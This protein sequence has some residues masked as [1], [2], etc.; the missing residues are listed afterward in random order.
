[1]DAI[2]QAISR[3]TGVKPDVLEG[4]V[5]LFGAYPFAAL[6]LLLP[7][8]TPPIYRHIYSIVV[9]SIL[10]SSTFS[11]ST[12]LHMVA[13]SA[14]TYLTVHILKTPY[15]PI[16]LFLFNMGYL[17]C[18]LIY[19]QILAA[20]SAQFDQTIPLMVLTIKL[21]SF[22]WSVHDGQM[23]IETLSAQQK[24]AMIKD[25]PGIIEFGGFVTWFPSFMVGP[26]VDFHDYHNFTHGL[27]PFNNIPST[28]IPALKKLVSSFFFMGL[29]LYIGPKFPYRVMA[30]VEFASTYSFL[31]KFG[32]LTVA[33]F[34]ERCKYYVAWGLSDGASTLTGFGYGGMNK[35]GTHDWTRAQNVNPVELETAENAK[36]IFESWNKKTAYWLRH[37][38]YERMLYRG[39][40][41]K[42]WATLATFI[43]SACWHG[44]HG[45]YYFGFASGSFITNSGRIA[46]RHF[47]HLFLPPSSLAPFKPIYD[48]LGW[49]ITITLTNYSTIPIV[50]F[51]LDTSFK[52]WKSF[53]FIPHISMLLVMLGFNYLGWGRYTHRLSRVFGAVEP[54]VKKR[55]GGDG[56]DTSK[57]TSN[58]N[59]KH[60][61]GL[62]QAS[63]GHHT[64][65]NGASSNG[66][67]KMTDKEV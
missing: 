15:M 26:A 62:K 63:N 12:V 67:G 35:D 55:G 54:G 56:K 53:Y 36:A 8:S 33:G 50:M 46:R 64:N 1:M 4:G 21:T 42:G 34:M 31:G 24:T 29:F 60:S 28:I 14:T 52:A 41:I 3:S 43:T 37:C 19:W 58:S 47:R 17:A 5:N 18:N 57:D 45:G 65:G 49:A 23:P 48:F 61:N 25:I 32:Y 38:V 22:A 44:Y 10:T 9:A 6:Y 13:M 27:P 59:S 11:M 66:T 2:I 51:A 30:T 16:L 7:R 40:K 20:S 39:D